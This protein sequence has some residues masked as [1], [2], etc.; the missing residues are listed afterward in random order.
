MQYTGKSTCNLVMEVLYNSCRYV[1]V[2]TYC[3]KSYHKT[4]TTI[5]INFTL[6]LTYSEK[7]IHWLTSHMMALI[8]K[9]SGIPSY[10]PYI[11][12][13]SFLLV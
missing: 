9:F 5:L 7:I 8:I 3:A 12:W 1:D 11:K 4:K 2:D 6:T 13:V 10:P